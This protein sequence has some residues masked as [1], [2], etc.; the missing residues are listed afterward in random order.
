VGVFQLQL[1][2]A[3]FIDV[4]VEDG[5]AKLLVCALDGIQLQCEQRF[6][7]GRTVGGEGGV[8]VF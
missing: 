8:T 6:A 7:G 2:V 3:G 1:H 4:L 5:N